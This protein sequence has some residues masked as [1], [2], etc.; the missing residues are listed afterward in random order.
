MCHSVN[1]AILR[2]LQEGVL[3]STTLMAPCPWALHAMHFLAG[4]PEIDFGVHLT[5]I[6]EWVDYRWGPVS[7]RE[8]VPSLVDAEGYFHNFKL[9][10]Q[11]PITGGRLTISEPKTSF[12][13]F[14]ELIQSLNLICNR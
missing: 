5:V 3:R 11:L 4:H 9:D 12:D 14:Q 7:A 10:H 2:A 13:D 1:E 8:K 6:S